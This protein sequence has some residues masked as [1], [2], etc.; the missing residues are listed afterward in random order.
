MGVLQGR[1][2]KWF[3]DH[4]PYA[5]N[6]RL[7]AVS[8]APSTVLNYEGAAET[9]KCSCRLGFSDIFSFVSRQLIGGSDA[10]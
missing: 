1:W 9:E 3:A 5:D 8:C 6:L 4:Q 10:L 7:L 2:A